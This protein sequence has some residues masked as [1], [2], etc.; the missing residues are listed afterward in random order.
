MPFE[1]LTTS[2]KPSL[3]NDRGPALIASLDEYEAATE[4]VRE[5]A[6]YPEGTPQAD[7]MAGLVQA[8]MEW[9]KT[10]DDATS[11]H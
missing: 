7:E 8:I 1:H 3:A 4:R 2:T 6:D 10:H 9:D 5:L 11:W